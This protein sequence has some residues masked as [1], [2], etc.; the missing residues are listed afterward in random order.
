MVLSL[1][2]LFIAMAASLTPLAFVEMIINSKSILS[3]TSVKAAK[4][5][6]ILVPLAPSIFKPFFFI[7]FIC[8]CH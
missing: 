3:G 4:D 1:T 8:S 6:F 2:I 5:L 7:L